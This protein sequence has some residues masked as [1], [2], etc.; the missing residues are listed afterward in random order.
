MANAA[1]VDALDRG[2]DELVKSERQ[3]RER[4]ALVALLQTKPETLAGCLATLRYLA[5]YAENNEA[6]L[7]HNWSP[8]VGTA[9]A[10][11]LPM[12]AD[13][14]EATVPSR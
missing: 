14:I 4:T 9:G 6:G 5:D 10:A 7:F 11:F 8:P 3:D 12:L 1:W 2:V 13:A